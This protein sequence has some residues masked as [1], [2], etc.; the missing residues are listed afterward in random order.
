MVDAMASPADT[1]V[2]VVAAKQRLYQALVEEARSVSGAAASAFRAWDGVANMM[3]FAAFSGSGW[4]YEAKNTVYLPRE[5]SA[6][7]HA[8]KIGAPYHIPDVSMAEHFK[9]LLPHT[10]SL[11]AV[12]I[13]SRGEVVG[14]FSVDWDYTTPDHVPHRNELL[15]LVRQFEGFLAV[16]DAREDAIQARL[17]AALRNQR[18]LDNEQLS[19]IAKEAAI[20]TKIAFAARGCS[21][22]IVFPHEK[23]AQLIATAGA[24]PTEVVQYDPGEGLT[25]WVLKTQRCLR[26]KDTS[27][28]A[29]LRSIDSELQRTERFVEDIEY[30]DAHGRMG[31]LAAP[32]IGNSDLVG[33]IRLTVKEDLTEFTA[34]EETLLLQIAREMAITIEDGWDRAKTSD[35]LTATFGELR[36]LHRLLFAYA[37]GP[38]LNVVI[39]RVL[40]AAIGESKMNVGI[41]RLLNAAGDRLVLRAHEGLPKNGLPPEL[42][43]NKFLSRS[44]SAEKP[45]YVQD[46]RN[47][48]DWL[49]LVTSLPPGGRRDYMATL[50]SFIHVPIRLGERCLGLILLESQQEVRISDRV[51]EFLGMLGSYAAVAI[52][53]AEAKNELLDTLEKTR[54]LALGGAIAAGIRHEVNNSLATLTSLSANL[55]DV[56]D[57]KTRLEAKLT[58]LKRELISFS[59]LAQ[60]LDL[61][62]NPQ[63]AMMA[64]LDLAETVF[65]FLTSAERPLLRDVKIIPEISARTQIRGNQA[66]LRVALFNIAKNA[67]DAMRG[68]GKLVVRVATDQDGYSVLTVEDNGPGMNPETMEHCF[69]PFYSGSTAR[70]R[71]LGLAAVKAVVDLHAADIYVSS[72]IGMGTTFSI[73]FPRIGG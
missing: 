25:G 72:E 15:R 52:Q 19:T 14:V 54:P 69:D 44:I 68:V 40:S 7:M 62:T 31:Y 22:F 60:G 4:T 71:G 48:R 32:M 6:G 11:L 41:V 63:G 61:A 10:R 8:F 12:P 20:S 55:L 65:A 49:E 42:E 59:E 26:V 56:I 30:S 64:P 18:S 21:I 3:R 17:V 46:C 67:V 66:L 70:G 5:K 24:Q 29:E 43:L 34:E 51:L 58:R 33:V 57:D 2:Q 23:R 47:D 1:L 37:T 28:D 36:H 9:L 39:R 16:L 35:E 53:L 38:D 73:K 27:N 45:F 50:R 13:R